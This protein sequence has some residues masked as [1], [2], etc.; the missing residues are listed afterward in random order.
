MNVTDKFDRLTDSGR[1]IHCGRCCA[2][3]DSTLPASVPPISTLYTEQRL[4]H[5]CSPTTT[6]KI[7]A[8]RLAVTV[9]LLLSLSS[10]DGRRPGRYRRV[11]FSSLAWS[12][13]L[14]RKFVVTRLLMSSLHGSVRSAFVA[15]IVYFTSGQGVP[16]AASGRSNKYSPGL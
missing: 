1:P 6:T 9:C 16:C 2:S 3:E 15:I 11:S 12:R 4:P 5:G 7:T 8:A 14:F 13:F 10:Q